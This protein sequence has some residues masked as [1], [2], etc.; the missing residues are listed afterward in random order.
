MN[1]F[2]ACYFKIT[3]KYAR[4]SF[5]FSSIQNNMN[6][7]KIIQKN[8]LPSILISDWK[9]KVHLFPIIYVPYYICSF[10]EKCRGCKWPRVE[11]MYLR[12]RIKLQ[13]LRWYVWKWKWI[14]CIPCFLRNELLLWL[15][16][17]LP[18]V[19]VPLNLNYNVCSI[20]PALFLKNLHLLVSNRHFFIPFIT[21]TL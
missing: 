13:R 21:L 14:F 2:F 16:C 10:C 8:F 6:M 5:R 17:W 1:I 9:L 12:K 3:L 19:K 7:K 18:W 15:L 20:P 4:A 11:M